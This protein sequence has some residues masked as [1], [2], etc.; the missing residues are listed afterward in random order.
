MIS[1]GLVLNDAFVKVAFE[2]NMSESG[3]NTS[4]LYLFY[5]VTE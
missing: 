5:E 4:I 1:R 2:L 3:D